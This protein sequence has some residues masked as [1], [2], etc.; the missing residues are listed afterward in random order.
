MADYPDFGDFAEESKSLDGDKKKIENILDQ[1]I[2]IVDFK[3]K[4]SKQKKGTLYT[5]IQF[6][7]DGINH[8]IFTGSGVLAEQLEKYKSN[9]PF[10]ATIKK[11]D[12][13]YIFT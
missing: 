6:K 7:I 9:L 8:V 1:R 13:Y 2:L 3:V 11:I 5:T 4:P 10:H 12:K